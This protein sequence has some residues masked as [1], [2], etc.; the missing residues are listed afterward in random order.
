M[1]D[2]VRA[3]YDKIVKNA[4]IKHG[5]MVDLKF[6]TFGWEDRSGLDTDYRK[7]RHSITCGIKSMGRLDEDACWEEFKGT[8][9]EGD[10]R[11]YGMD[12]HDVTCNCGLITGRTFRWKESVG[13]AIRLVMMELLE[14]KVASEE[15]RSTGLPPEVWKVSTGM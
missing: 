13:E 9:Y 11:V 10:T 1:D 4:I 15:K 2:K 3:E 7:P 12:V 8:F 5:A 6:S 14:E